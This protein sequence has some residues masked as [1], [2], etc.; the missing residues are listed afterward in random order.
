MVI[1]AE[2]TQH[3]ANWYDYLMLNHPAAAAVD[4]QA[5]NGRRRS[6]A[7]KEKYE[8]LA[9]D[10]VDREMIAQTVRN[11]SKRPRLD[12]IEA[13]DGES[14]TWQKDL[15][16]FRGTSLIK[17]SAPLGPYGRTMPGPLQ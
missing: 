7:E 6:A 15:Y 3:K 13:L 4:Q 12:A 16:I 2:K 8:R 10:L 17:D 1:P 5:E 9:A 14:Q 11:A